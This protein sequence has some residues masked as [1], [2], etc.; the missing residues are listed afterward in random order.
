MGLSI[1]RQLVESHKGNVVV[2]SGGRGQGS[3]F[4]VTLPLATAERSEAFDAFESH[5]RSS[6]LETPDPSAQKALDVSGVRVLVVE[7]DPDS[8]ELV[9]AL[10]EQHYAHVR[11]AESAQEALGMFGDW[12]PQ[13]LLLDIA[14]AGED[15][16]SLMRKLK[17]QVR[18]DNHFVAIALTAYASDEDRLRVLSCGF[19]AHLAKPIDHERLMALLRGLIARGE[20]V[21]Q[22][23]S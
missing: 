5:D 10:I 15:G 22:P 13:L 7:D 3:T 11:C 19:R 21:S 17:A 23:A 18:H 12:K 14:M 2:S 16:Y 4:R 1:V 8:R 9:C 20:I 6:T